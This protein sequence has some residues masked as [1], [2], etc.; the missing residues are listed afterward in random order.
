MKT[1]SLTSSFDFTFSDKFGSSKSSRSNCDIGRKNRNRC[2][3]TSE[4]KFK[5]MV[6]P[7]PLEPTIKYLDDDLSNFG[8]FEGIKQSKSTAHKFK[9][10]K[11]IRKLSFKEA[12]TI[13]YD[14]VKRQ[15]QF[16]KVQN[17]SQS[18]KRRKIKFYSKNTVRKENV[19]YLA[20]LPDPNSHHPIINLKNL[21]KK[22][23]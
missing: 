8:Y 11:V 12:E 20:N 17:S 14:S 3:S 10:E 1:E 13:D 4:N 22:K 18:N 19:Q 15:L 2:E 9:S 6:L 5:L 21:K 16:R 23:I 7:P